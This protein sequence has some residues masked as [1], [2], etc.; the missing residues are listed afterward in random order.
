MRPSVA[1]WAAVVLAA[2]GRRQDA[3]D[4]LGRV[5]P[6]APRTYADE[7]WLAVAR[8]AVLPDASARA[9]SADEARQIVAATQDEI[10]Q[11]N[12][13]LAVRLLNGGAPHPSDPHGWARMWQLVRA[14]AGLDHVVETG[15]A[16]P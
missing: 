6:D 4:A 9:V 8:A 5:P 2:A 3:E 1:P 15:A 11:R 10:S 13:E 7:M 12:I 14:G 16:I